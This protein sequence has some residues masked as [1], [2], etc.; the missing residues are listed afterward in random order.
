MDNFYFVI[1]ITCVLTM[2]TLAI[3]VGKNTI[4]SKTDIKFFRITFIMVAL[5]VICEFFGYYFDIHAMRPLWIHS[6]VTLLEFSIA[7]LLSVLFARSCGIHKSVKVMSIVMALHIICQIIMLPF[8]G[9]FYINSDGLYC[10]GPFYWIYLAVGGIAFLYIFIIFTYLGKKSHSNN[11]IKIILISLILIIGQVACFIDDSIKSGYIS[12]SITAVLLYIFV[13]EFIR[14][15]MLNT[16]EKEQEISN[17]DPLTG[18]KSRIFY[19]RKIAEIDEMIAKN[20]NLIHFA[21]C[22]CDLNNLKL[23]ND[24]YG[25]ESGDLYIQKCCKVI[26]SFFKYSP[27]FRIG[28]DEF[29]VILQNEDYNNCDELKERFLSFLNNEAIRDC[30]LTEKVSFAIGFSKFDTAVDKSVKDVF[31]RADKEMYLHKHEL[32]KY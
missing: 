5:G 19:D 20:K 24:T 17:Q 4:L 3:D 23:I 27:V 32:K 9:I 21:I 30:V 25:H 10:R 16:I 1:I 22:E 18:V 26:C 8:G 13:Q 28:G 11:I 7:P 2:L 14:I 6:I 29:V 15:K 12:L 31:S